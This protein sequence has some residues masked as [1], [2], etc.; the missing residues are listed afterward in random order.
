MTYDSLTK[1]PT[2]YF[3]EIYMLLK[4]YV[5]NEEEEIGEGTFPNNY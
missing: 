3:K 5:K 1:I 2:G 4:F